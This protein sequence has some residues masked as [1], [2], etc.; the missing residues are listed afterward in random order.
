MKRAMAVVIACVALTVLGT[1][2]SALAATREHEARAVAAKPL[3][4]FKC[5]EMQGKRIGK[6]VR[7]RDQFEAQEAQLLEPRRFCNPVQKTYHDKVT[8]IQDRDAHLQFYRIESAQ[9]SPTRAVV[10]GNQFGRYQKLEVS[11]P[12]FLAVPTQKL[13]PGKHAPPEGLD[14][15]KCYAARGDHKQAVVDLRDEFHGEP[16]IKVGDPR[17]FCN[18]VE[19]TLDDEITRIQ[20]P[21]AH[22]VCYEFEGGR[23]ERTVHTRNQVGEG[24]FTVGRADLLCVPSRKLRFD[25][26]LVPGE[27]NADDVRLAKLA[28]LRGADARVRPPEWKGCTSPTPDFVVTGSET[29]VSGDEHCFPSDGTGMFGPRSDIP[30]LNTVDGMDVADMD[31]DGDNDFLACDGVTSEVYLY[32]QGPTGV[33]TPS[34]VASGITSGVG[35]SLFCT[36]LRVGDFNTDGMEDFVVGD[37]RV[38]KGM[39]VYLQG[40]VGTFTKVGPGLDVTWASPSGAACNC[41]FGLAA[42]DV[43]GDGNEDVL[44][45]GYRGA[46]AGELHFYQGNGTGGMAAPV[47]KFDLGSDF[48]VVTAPTGLALFDVDGDGDLD[49]LA[50]GSGDGSH[51]VYT[52]DGAGNFTAPPGPVFNLQNYS[53]A[54]AYDFDGNGD[55]DLVLVDWTTRRLVYVENLGGTLAAPVAAGALDGASIGVGAPEPRVPVTEGLDH[56]KCYRTEGTEPVDVQVFLQ[57]QFGDTNGLVLEAVRFCNPIQKIHDDQVT[58]VK[59]RHAHLTLYRLDVDRDVPRRVVNVSNQFGKEQ[60]IEVAE[61]LFLAV[62]TQKRFPGAHP[63]PKG[64]DHFECYRADGKPLEAVVD[65]KDQFH[66]EPQVKVYAPFALC[67][68]VEK[69]YGDVMTEVQHPDDHLMCYRIERRPFETQVR[70]RNQFGDESFSAQDA[71]V[72]CVPSRK[73]SPSQ[74]PNIT[75]M[76]G[77]RD[78]VDFDGGMVAPG[79]PG[80]G[81]LQQNPDATWP[82]GRPRRPCGQY[83]PID[84]FLPSTGVKRFRI[85]YRPHTDPVPLLG[86]APGIHTKWILRDR[87]VTPSCKANAA[88]VLETTGPQAWMDA[89]AYLEAKLGGPSTD[90]CPNSG[91]RL[92][93]WDTANH[94]GLGPPDKDGHYVMWLE[95]EDTASVLH[96]EPFEHHLQLDNTLPNLND[97][98]VTLQDGTTPVG[99]CGEAPEGEHIFKVY[100]DFEDDFYWSYRLRV[101]GG[102]PPKT[103]TYGWHNY[104]DGT[105]FVA[106]T[107]KTG[108]TPPGSTVFLRDVDMND[109]GASFTDCCYLLELFVRDAAIRHSFNNQVANET[110]GGYWDDVSKFITFSAAPA[111]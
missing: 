88:N 62:P 59:N 15:F 5:Y 110:T 74:D 28:A 47:L 2:A 83:V 41:L 29:V 67:N 104:Y 98:L 85:A 91:L 109:F 99:A 52:N 86:T 1:N 32:T 69:Q 87:S 12:L 11:R 49:V 105:S 79:D 77:D 18:P 84:G 61:P 36:N 71:D 23:F 30:G 82:D 3:D 34:T 42:G 81:L 26:E 73:T 53:G 95:W 14:H 45:L 20:N 7:L 31:G 40:P 24:R 16:E 44:V 78:A 37:N 76:C 21:Q 22:L 111:P 43:D 100:A 39:F 38:T 96:R 58:R 19:K 8:S 68:P 4:H 70:V 17:L 48:P 102:N 103:V 63:A 60:R 54:D 72:L 106:N 94:D 80:T 35:G 6:K 90:W 66:S 55:E 93:V 89:D 107:D 65:L 51:Y 27:L 9:R 97:L 56:F 50:G 33:F 46:G 101:R 13:E 75:Q 108:T 92:A 64:L 10:V 57:D 25:L